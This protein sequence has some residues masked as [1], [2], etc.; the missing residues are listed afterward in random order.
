MLESAVCVQRAECV[1]GGAVC[2]PIE[3]VD[4]AFPLVTLHFGKVVME[5]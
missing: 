3:R 4:P 1:T 5:S 2:I